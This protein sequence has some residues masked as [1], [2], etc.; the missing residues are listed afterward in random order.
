MLKKIG[1]RSKNAPLFTAHIPRDAESRK[2]QKTSKNFKKHQ[3]TF[4]KTLRTRKFFM[5]KKI[6]KQRIN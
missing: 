1:K 2:L 6:E 5:L 4:K 3:N